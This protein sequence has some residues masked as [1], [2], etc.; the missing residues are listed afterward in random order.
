MAYADWKAPVEDGQYLIWP[1]P[2]ELLAQTWENQRAL[3]SSEARVGNIAVG[4][5]RRRLREFLGHDDQQPLIASGHQAELYHAGVWVKDVLLEAMARPLGAAAYHFAVDTDQPKHLQLR[6]PTLVG[7]GTDGA[8]TVCAFPIT[9]DPEIQTAEWASLLDAPT[10]A[11]IATISE[12]L[13]RSKFN[14]Q[15]LLGEFLL[16][17][18][19]LSI[20]RPNL[21]SALTNA[22]HELS[23]SLGLRHHALLCS[24]MWISEPYLAF[25]HHILSQPLQFASDYNQALAD[26]RREQKLRSPSRPMPDLHVT[27]T[28]CEVPF[29][30]DNL[31][32]NTRERATVWRDGDYL[33]LV[34][35]SGDE[36]ALD[37]KTDGWEAA[38]K[39]GAF[40]RRNQLRLSPRALTMTL[41]LRLLV[42]D[43]FVHG[44]GGGRYDQ[45]TDRLIQSHF[46]IKP[47]YFGVTTATLYFPDALT[48]SRACLPCV[49]GDGHRLRHRLLGER[50]RELVAAIDSAPRNSLERRQIFSQM[51]QELTQAALRNPELERW[52]QN[53]RETEQREAEEQT[54]FDREL[55]FAV[56]PRERLLELI[57]KYAS[58]FA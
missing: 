9:D 4:E 5:L 15:P 12:A 52:E 28:S 22:S 50:K 21:A 49:V 53:L 34:A 25:V 33:A 13:A 8:H 56:Q 19:R 10:P 36:F 57:S 47:P 16:S 43:N 44:I 42:V 14:F 6:W 18:R 29:W 55:F 31:A 23:W 35:P 30:F 45:V 7:G 26:Y 24:P 40:C 37:A 39:L 32:T 51:H 17:L 58:R 41:F 2:K 46:K 38:A 1:E 54:L 48:Q 27:P 3:A 20:E 11:H